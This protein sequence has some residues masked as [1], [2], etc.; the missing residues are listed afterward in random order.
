[1]KYKYDHNSDCAYIS[2]NDLPHAY[3]KE[4]DEARFVDYAKDDTVIGVELLYVSGGVDVSGLPHEAEIS[5]ILEKHKI[6]VFA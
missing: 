4:I 1:V 6:K 2:I 3:S 5:K